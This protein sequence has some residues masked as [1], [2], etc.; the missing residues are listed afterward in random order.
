MNGNWRTRTRQFKRRIET[1]KKLKLELQG[2][3][4]LMP[5]DTNTE[6]RLIALKNS[7]LEIDL[8]FMWGKWGKIIRASWLLM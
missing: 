4:A 8:G 6:T 2:V 5:N 3:E 1:T 7:N